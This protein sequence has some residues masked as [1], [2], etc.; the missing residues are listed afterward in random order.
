MVVFRSA[1]R[2]SGQHFQVGSSHFFLVS[3]LLSTYVLGK[4]AAVLTM[5]FCMWPFFRSSYEKDN[6]MEIKAFCSVFCVI[7][8]A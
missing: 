1:N 2:I 6:N 3:F 7:V 5:V 4:M 8:G